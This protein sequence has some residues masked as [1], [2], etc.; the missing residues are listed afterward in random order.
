MINEFV[1]FRVVSCDFVDRSLEPGQNLM[2]CGTSFMLPGNISNARHLPNESFMSRCGLCFGNVVTAL[3]LIVFVVTLSSSA[4]AQSSTINRSFDFRNGDLGWQADF[5]N[6]SPVMFVPGEPFAPLAEIRSLPPELGINGTGFFIQAANRSDAIV[7]FLKRRLS[8]ADGIVAGQTYQLNFTVTF[9][10]AAQSGCVGIGGAPGEAVVMREGA[11]SAEPTVLLTNGSPAALAMN[12]DIGGQSSSGLAA[13]VS[14]NIANGIPCGS[15][16]PNYVQLQQSHQ[17][18]SLV[19]AG[20]SG[21][22][23]LFVGTASGYEGVTGLYYERIDVSLTPMSS[24]PPPVLV[25]NKASGRAAA[26]DSQGL[27][28]GPFRVFSEQNF[29][30]SDQH[31]RIN[32]FAYNLQLKAGE[33]SGAIT[34]AAQ[35]SQGKIYALPVEAVNEVPNFNWISQVTVRLPDELA[36]AGDILVYVKLRGVASNKL[37]I[38]VN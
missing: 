24:P 10:S 8:A 30:S 33:D 15:A 20:S 31:T 28:D 38:Q 14:G 34:V 21:D 32:L 29:F 11:S 37:P 7:M 25:P 23:W 3:F 17:H 26:L 19:N 5:A 18:I 2:N 4:F 9:A 36:G 6:Y 1:I 12:M 13:S 27:R 22:L 16:P 35:D